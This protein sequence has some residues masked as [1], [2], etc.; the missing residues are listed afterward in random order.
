MFEI[1]DHFINGRL[2]CS[3]H[4]GGSSDFAGLDDRAKGLKLAMGEA[5]EY[6]RYISFRNDLRKYNDY[7]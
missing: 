5:G 4:V 2:C 7:S 6:S 1:C 3:Q